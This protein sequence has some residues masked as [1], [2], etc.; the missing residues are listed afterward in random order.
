MGFERRKFKR[1]PSKIVG[2]YLASSAEEARL[3][4]NILFTKDISLR[5]VRI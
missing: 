1:M 2:S 5:G 4:S 3:K